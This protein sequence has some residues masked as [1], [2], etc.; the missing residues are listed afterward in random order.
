MEGAR[1]HLASGEILGNNASLIPVYSMEYL[2]GS[3]AVNKRNHEL[4]TQL[5]QMRKIA[6]TM[7]ESLAALL[8]GETKLH[9]PIYPYEVDYNSV[10]DEFRKRNVASVT[11]LPRGK[12]MAFTIQTGWDYIDLIGAYPNARWKFYISCIQ[13]TDV[14][15]A[16]GKK[17]VRMLIGDVFKS[18]LTLQI[19]SMDHTYDS[20]DLYT[21]HPKELSQI[22]I[23]LYTSHKDMFI[24]APRV[25]QRIID[26]SVPVNQIGLVQEPAG[27]KGGSH[28]NRM[29]RLGKALDEG[30]SFEEACKFARVKQLAPWEVEI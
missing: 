11:R 24:D 2:H 14:R 6:S 30:R 1:G 18:H 25:F 7:G 9:N 28:S 27:G 4:R 22:L 3:L 29:G 8:G 10:L 23:K 13:D 19:K 21:W 12:T 5:Q 26:P 17:F 15:R 16:L 20:L